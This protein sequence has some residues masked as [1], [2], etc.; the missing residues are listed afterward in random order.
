MKDLKVGDVV[1]MPHNPLNRITHRGETGPVSYQV[2][3]ICKSVDRHVATIKNKQ[4]MKEIIETPKIKR[5][6]G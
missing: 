2:V 1:E 6:G 5:R 4:S 3:D